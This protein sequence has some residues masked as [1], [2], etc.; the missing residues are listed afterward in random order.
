MSNS[1]EEGKK[2]GRFNC[3]DFEVELK[4]KKP[5]KD[6]HKFVVDLSN[7]LIRCS[8]CLVTEFLPTKNINDKLTRDFINEFKENHNCK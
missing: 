3:H 2:F 8:N 6:T 7:Q 4:K 5:K 1:L